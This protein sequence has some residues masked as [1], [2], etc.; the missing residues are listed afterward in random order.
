M[1]ISNQDTKSVVEIVDAPLM[2]VFLFDFLYRLFTTKSKSYYFFR[3]WGW[4]DLLSSLPV[5]GTRIFRLFRLNRVVGL[6]NAYGPKKAVYDLADDRATIALSI[7]SFLVILIIEIACILVL[8]AESTAANSN[9][10]TAGE[11]I[12]WAIVTITTVGYGD[13]TPVTP[14]GRLIGIVLMIFGVSLL[15]VLTGYLASAFLAPRRKKVKIRSEPTDPKAKISEIRRIIE[16]Q[17]KTFADLK[18]RLDEIEKLL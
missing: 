11:S 4:A 12:W 2:L 18:A 17:E 6:L 10:R 1:P 8:K 5:T 9:L 13:Y 15:A 7:I 14:N 16:K 3:N